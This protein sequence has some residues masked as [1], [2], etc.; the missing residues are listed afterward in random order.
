MSSLF[1]HVVIVI[2]LTIV[3]TLQWH[4]ASI[5]SI[6]S[7]L[8]QCYKIQ[9]SVVFGSKSYIQIGGQVGEFV[10]Q[11]KICKNWL[12]ICILMTC[13][14]I[15]WWVCSKLQSVDLIWDPSLV[16]ASGI[17]NLYMLRLLGFWSFATHCYVMALGC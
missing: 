4:L 16:S 8:V 14:G 1:N 5:L 9:T 12:W 15:W 10:N 11:M 2:S 13:I 7:T 6:P 17:L 3:M